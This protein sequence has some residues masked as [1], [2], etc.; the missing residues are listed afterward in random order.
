M[1]GSFIHWLIHSPNVY[2]TRCLLGTGPVTG[3]GDAMVKAKSLLYLKS[4]F[5]CHLLPEPFSITQSRS[6]LPIH[7]HHTTLS[8]LQV[9][10]LYL[11]QKCLWLPKTLLFIYLLIHFFPVYPTLASPQPPENIRSVKAG[12][13]TSHLPLCSL[14]SA[15]YYSLSAPIIQPNFNSKIPEKKIIWAIHLLFF[16]DSVDVWNL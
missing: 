16:V 13:M 4:Q 6:H 10:R 2:W 8:P 14:H 1:N 11:I 7:H 12:T 3:N 15:G 9:T 5:Y